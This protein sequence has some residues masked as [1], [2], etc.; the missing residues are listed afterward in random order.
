MYEIFEKLCEINGITPYRFEKD[1]NVNSSTISTWKKKNSLAGPELAEKVC[2]YF[3]VSMD[4][5]MGKTDK[6]LCPEC[7]F[8]Y[9]PLNK[10]SSDLHEQVHSDYLNAVSKYG[11]CHSS[12]KCRNEVCGYVNLLSCPTPDCSTED[13]A[14]A[15][16]KY[17]EINF[18]DLLRNSNYN[19]KY[20]SFN[21]YVE[22]QVIKDK[23]ENFM[24]HDL[25]NKL[26][27]EYNIDYLYTGENTDLIIEIT[28]KL[29]NDKSFAE[30]MARYM[31]LSDEGKKYADSS[32]DLMY[33]KEHKGED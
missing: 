30:R 5:L 29:N 13:I 7:E 24:S 14:N 12:D 11:F 33:I 15:Y 27:E 16:I 31:S 18:S 23:H 19:L 6:I 9:D 17:L 21:D 4:F 1:M 10:E 3:K 26:S 28:K 8:N 32:I 22:E 2:N 25:F 20:D